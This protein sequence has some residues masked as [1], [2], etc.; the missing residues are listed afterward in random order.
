MVLANCYNKLHSIYTFNIIIVGVFSDQGVL[1]KTVSTC[2]SYNIK[3][4]H[5]RVN[6]KMF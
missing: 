4:G 6:D 2:K 3:L 1:L 5:S